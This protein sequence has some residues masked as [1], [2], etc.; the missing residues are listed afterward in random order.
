MDIIGDIWNILVHFIVLLWSG[1][2]NQF[3]IAA[4]VCFCLV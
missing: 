1:K 3:R 4:S 2:H